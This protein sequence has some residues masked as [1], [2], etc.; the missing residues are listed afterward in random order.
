MSDYWNVKEKLKPTPK[1]I[2]NVPL[3]IGKKLSEEYGN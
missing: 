1:K 3:T 2:V